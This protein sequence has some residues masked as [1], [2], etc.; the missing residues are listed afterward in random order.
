M[1]DIFILKAADNVYNSVYLTDIGQKLIAQ[2]FAL[3]CSFY[4]TGNINEFDNS[5]SYLFGVIQIA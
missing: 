2:T 4:Q 3:G 5:W 1:N